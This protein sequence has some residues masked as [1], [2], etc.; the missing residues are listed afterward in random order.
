LTPIEAKTLLNKEDRETVFSNI[1]EISDY[2]VGFNNRIKDIVTRGDERRK[3]AGSGGHHDDVCMLDFLKLFE[4]NLPAFHKYQKYFVNYPTS[5]FCLQFFRDH[6]PELDAFSKEAQ[7]SA[8]NGY[9]IADVLIMP[10]QMQPRYIMLLEQCQKYT[11]M[12]PQTQAAPYHPQ[13]PNIHKECGELFPKVLESLR[14]GLLKMN[15]QIQVE[16]LQVYQQRVEK[17]TDIHGWP[18]CYLHSLNRKYIYDGFLKVKEASQTWHNTK[19]SKLRNLFTLFDDILV[20]SAPPKKGLFDAKN[21]GGTIKGA[22]ALQAM[23]AEDPDEKPIFSWIDGGPVSLN[24]EPA[25]HKKENVFEFTLAGNQWIVEAPNHN[26]MEKWLSFLK[27]RKA[28][29]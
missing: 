15:S 21:K 19:K 4:E 7:V 28:H 14:T 1:R 5:N 20:V 16:N 23:A 8:L 27:E 9:S 26:E 24:L 12:V 29:S 11:M 2:H 17:Q 10:G 22:K 3:Q 25:D 6:N 18:A 13:A